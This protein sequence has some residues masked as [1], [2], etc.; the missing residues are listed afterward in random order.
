ML[1]SN[2][3]F[4]QLLYINAASV[5]SGARFLNETCRHCGGSL[6]RVRQI[7][8]KSLAMYARL[9]YLVGEPSQKL[10]HI[11]FNRAPR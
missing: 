8:Q 9:K 4:G 2:H 11:K 1:I 6:K 7:L 3:Q 10:E 5:E